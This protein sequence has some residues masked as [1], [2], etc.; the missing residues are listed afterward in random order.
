MLLEKE[1][2]H[3]G[4]VNQEHQRIDQEL[5]QAKEKQV[6]KKVELE[7]QTKQ[8]IVFRIQSTSRKCHLCSDG[9][10]KGT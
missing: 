3:Y 5:K 8:S 7:T 9:Y 1:H 6:N 4:E 10:T 2:D